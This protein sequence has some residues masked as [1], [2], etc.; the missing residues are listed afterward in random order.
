MHPQVLFMGSSEFSVPI[1][2]QLNAENWINAVITQPDK[3]TGRG[4]KLESPVVKN[5]AALLRLPIYQPGKMS[6]EE[7]SSILDN[8]DIDLIV[9]AAYGKI[10][11]VW[12][13]D[14]PKFGALNVHASLLPRW[15]GAS[16]IQAAILHGDPY[17]G[18]TI[19]IMDEGLDTGDILSQESLTVSTGETAESLS[20]KLAH[21]GA[22]LLSQTI[23]RFIEGKIIPQKQNPEEAT[24]TQMIRKED[25]RLNFQE[26]A[27]ILERKIRAYNPW[28]ICFFD[29]DSETLRIYEA[30][31]TSEISLQP[32]ERGVIKKYPCVGTGTDS[33]LLR[34]VQPPG[35]SKMDGRSFLNGAKNWLV[36]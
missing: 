26:P 25:G 21:L 28:P 2:K 20:E 3:P 11:P 15:R 9:V 5:T 8:H 27:E 14:Y 6:R 24:M 10:L 32:Y 4:K 16:P 7:I 31:V 19:M 33:L 22:K 12:M 30:E 13:L 35:R 18:V 23:V 17:T 36:S 29:W 1:L 34:S